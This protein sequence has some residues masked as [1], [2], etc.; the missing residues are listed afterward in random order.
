M[1]CV[2]KIIMDSKSNMGQL[3]LN[4]KIRTLNSQEEVKRNLL[5][6]GVREKYAKL[7]E[8][9]PVLEVIKESNQYQ[10]LLDDLIKEKNR[11]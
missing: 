11:T 2:D 9:R 3:S 4:K 7:E 5:I 1:T 8:R 6:K 10:K